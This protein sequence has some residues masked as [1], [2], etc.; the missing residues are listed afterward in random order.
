M[1]MD[2]KPPVRI[3]LNITKKCNLNCKHCFSDSGESQDDEL[4]T[5]ELYS[6]INQMKEMG[7]SYIT[8][9]G[10]EPLIRKDIFDVLEYAS[11]NSIKLSVV[12]NC[13]LM[14]KEKATRLNNLG[15]KKIKV[16]IDGMEKN[17]N[18]T[19]GAGVFESTVGKIKLLRKYFK[20]HIQIGFTIN[21]ENIG[22]YRD[23]IKLAE[24]LGVDSLRLTPILP[25]GR[26]LRYKYLLLNQNQ[27]ID[28]V[29]KVREIDSTIEIDL[30]DKARITRENK[31]FGCHC[32]K[33][34][35]WILENGDF[36]PCIFFGEQFKLG[37]IK[38]SS[39]EKLWEKS[40][41]AVAFCGNKIC[42][43]CPKY[44]ECRGGCRARALYAYNDINAVDPFCLFKKNETTISNNNNSI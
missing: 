3:S 29:K 26:A 10:G 28:F 40:K 12:T 4:L 32:G 27:F 34:A 39:L 36:Y 25:F 9:G 41:E 20:N 5:E 43:N 8:V 16:S 30:P 21:S 33:E 24:D 42:N 23:I 13:I 37:N 1:N 38:R 19:R 17:H 18:K 15:V 14:T 31:G 6:L 7:C 44:E 11:K 22:D 35:C 2:N